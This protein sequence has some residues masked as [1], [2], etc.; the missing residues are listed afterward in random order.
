MSARFSL[1]ADIGGTHA[2]FALLSG[3]DAGGDDQGL[4]LHEKYR[5]QDFD[6]FEEVLDNYLNSINRP[7][8]QYASISNAGPVFSD[9]VA[10]TKLDWEFSIRKL[11]NKFHLEEL[12]VIN[13]AAAGALATS[14]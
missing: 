10:M 1:V 5:C 3:Q 6:S 8:L 14:H 7:L 4:M 12:L 2:R 11:K 13:V 9:Q